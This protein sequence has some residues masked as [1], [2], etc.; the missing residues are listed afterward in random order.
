MYK[1]GEAFSSQLA[2]YKRF[3]LR[4]SWTKNKPNYTRMLSLDIQNVF[5]FQNDAY[6]MYDPF[7]MEVVTETQLGII[8]VLSYRVEF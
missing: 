1:E 3:D 8:P 4:I 7:L 5:S 2:D 6:M